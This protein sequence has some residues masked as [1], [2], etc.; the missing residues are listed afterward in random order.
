LEA[1]E[2][3]EENEP[4]ATRELEEP[5]REASRGKTIRQRDGHRRSVEWI[6]SDRRERL[7]DIIAS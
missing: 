4:P 5:W 2:V 6:Y 1:G 7:G 3:G